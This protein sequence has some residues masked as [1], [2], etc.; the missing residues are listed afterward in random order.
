MRHFGLGALVLFAIA[1]CGS[2]NAGGGS[3]SVTGTV[4]G[5]V[6]PTN[7][8]IAL[9]GPVTVTDPLTGVALTLQELL[10]LVSN[11][12]N[13]CAI[14]QGSHNPPNITSLGISVGSVNPIVT[15][16]FPVGS[17]S[18]DPAAGVA[19]TAVDAMCMGTTNQGQSGTVTI[20]TI[21]STTVTGNFDVLLTSGDHLSG[22]FVAPV[23][24][25]DLNALTNSTTACGG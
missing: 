25:A 21:T 23:C 6:V 14:A 3:S 5:A 9:V 22:H 24:N 17:A 2:S 15:G 20:S 8:T 12:P 11:A 1:A 4:S 10:V 19:Y 16:T 18:A 13:L 7:D